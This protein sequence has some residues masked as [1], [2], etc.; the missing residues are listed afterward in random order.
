MLGQSY[1]TKKMEILPSETIQYIFS[2]LN[3]H[4]VVKCRLISAR[5]SKI[6]WELLHHP[7]FDNIFKETESRSYNEFKSRTHLILQHDIHKPHLRLTRMQLFII[8]K[9]QENT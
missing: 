1:L 4:I 8:L 2:F 9:K 7:K 5:F 3:F 6:L